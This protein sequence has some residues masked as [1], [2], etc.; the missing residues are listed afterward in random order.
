[1]FDSGDIERYR[2]QKAPDGLYDRI[3]ADAPTRKKARLLE[4]RAFVRSVSSVAACFIFAVALTFMLRN[5][6]SEVYISVSG[7]DLREAGETAYVS[8]TP[9]VLARTAEAPA[10]IPVE[11]RSKTEVTVDAEHGQVWCT[12]DG[13]HIMREL[14]CTAKAGDLLYWVPD[15]A[16]HARLTLTS[17]SESVTYTVESGDDA[18]DIRIVFEK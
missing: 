12:K 13:A 14:P 9:S 7:T 11:I 2:S 17:D 8:V 5:T 1:M 10:G 6:P 4:S 3:L 18:A 16:E 15:M